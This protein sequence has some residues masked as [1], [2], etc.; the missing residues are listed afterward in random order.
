MT[1]ETSTAGIPPKSA[2]QHRATYSR[3]KLNGGWLVRVVGPRAKEFAGRVV[4]V[5]TTHGE[6]TEKLDALIWSGVDDGTYTKEDAG[7]PVGLY[8]FKPRPKEKTEAAF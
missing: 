8:S 5:E 2:R 7:K 4:P 3:D 6:D 1:K